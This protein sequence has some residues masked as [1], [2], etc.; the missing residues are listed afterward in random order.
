MQAAQGSG[1]LLRLE[2]VSKTYGNY[3]ALEP[4]TIAVNEGEFFSLLGP[5]GCGKTTTLR[6]IAGFETPTTGTVHLGGR[7]ISRTPPNLRDTN[8]VF[9]SYALFPHM[10][11]TENV[12]YPL[13]MKNVPAAEIGPRV[14]EAIAQVEMSAFGERLPHEMSGGQR[15]R[16]AL[17]RAMVGRPRVLLLDEPLGA[18]DLKLREQ[19]Q[20]MLVHL[21]RKIGITF[22]YVTHDQGEALSM[23]DRIAVMS[24]G[25]VQQLAS[26]R[27]IYYQPTNAFVASFIGKSN[28][29]TGMVAT[30][31]G[32]TV[33]KA[34][35]L[36]DR[37]RRADGEAQGRAALRSAR[38][39]RRRPRPAMSSSTRPW[40]TRCSRATRS[41]SRSIS[42]ATGWWPWFPRSA[43]AVSGRAIA[44]RPASI[45]ATWCCSMTDA[46][47]STNGLG[48]LIGRTTRAPTRPPTRGWRPSGPAR[49]SGMDPRSPRWATATCTTPSGGYAWSL[50]TDRATGWT[51]ACGVSP[52]GDQA[53]N[54]A[55]APSAAVSVRSTAASS[56]AVETNQV[57]RAVG[58]T[59]R[60]CSSTR[61]RAW[62]PASARA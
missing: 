15:Q 47:P 20:H 59:P 61:K 51:P 49:A 12:A 43:I 19:M 3:Q 26:P 16:I 33:L 9:Q 7:D 39:R 58:R 60:S 23:S 21:Q 27:D 42:A 5:S 14:T 6:I 28:V 1:P 57:P 46:A 30:E 53:A 8:T 38:D 35:P 62:R 4:T 50:P 22:V 17:A 29:L 11:A 56:W 44:S 52:S 13:R 34:G 36:V 31:G 25:R 45:P 37:P 24:A 41:R 18:L 55:S 54:A 48:A 10:T 32:R 40:R 2:G